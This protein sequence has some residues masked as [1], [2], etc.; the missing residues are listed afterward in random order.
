MLEA[1]SKEKGKVLNALDFPMPLATF[2]AGDL[3]TDILAWNLTAANSKGI[4][5]Y[6]A[7]D[8]GSLWN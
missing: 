2:N 4:L 1:S 5:I 3:A 8:M 6:P 7:A